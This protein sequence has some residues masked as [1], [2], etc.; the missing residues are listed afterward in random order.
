MREAP[1]DH[2]PLV[3]RGQLLA[4]LRALG[5]RPG[6]RGRPGDTLMFRASVR[7]LGWI[8][9]GSRV[10]LAAL[11]ALLTPEGTLLMLAS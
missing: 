4:D 10:V 11:L 5:A 1:N 8:V 6:D 9:G 2:P 7:A 3:T